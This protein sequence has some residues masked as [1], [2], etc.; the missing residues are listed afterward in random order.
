MKAN[1][2]KDEAEPAENPE[3]TSNGQPEGA[4]CDQEKAQRSPKKG[5]ADPAQGAELAEDP[6][7]SEGVASVHDPQ[8]SGVAQPGRPRS[9]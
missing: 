8:V 6:Q 1:V 3:N 9:Q 2:R 7:E 4:P 5:A